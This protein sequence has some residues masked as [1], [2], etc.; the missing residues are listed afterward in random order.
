MFLCLHTSDPLQEITGRTVT[1]YLLTL[2]C[3]MMAGSLLHLPHPPI[4][5]GRRPGATAKDIVRCFLPGM[6]SSNNLIRWEF[7]SFP[8]T[9]K[10]SLECHS[11]TDLR[12]G[13]FSILMIKKMCHW[14]TCAVHMLSWIFIRARARTRLNKPV[15][16]VSLIQVLCCMS[17]P[18]RTRWDGT[19]NPQ[20]RQLT[21]LN[22]LCY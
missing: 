4:K 13:E 1:R 22:K 10:M 5:T 15:L 9:P 21:I 11:H 19:R 14:L 18:Y 3:S 6:I 12:T 7:R 17:I 16:V 20:G 8:Q 2:L